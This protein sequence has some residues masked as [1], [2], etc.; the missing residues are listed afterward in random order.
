MRRYL[1]ACKKTTGSD[2]T[3]TWA[4]ADF[5]A[6]HEVHGWMNMPVWLPAEGE[7]AGF[8]SR[9]VDRAVKAGLVFRPLQE[10]IADTLTW[11]DGL[12]EERRAGVTQRAGIP[13][14]K[15]AEV[16]AAWHAR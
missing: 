6:G 13:A 10:T 9:S 16:L 12:D 4:D 3:F 1:E 15:E 14:E 2:A 5:L 8:G 11:F 7:Y